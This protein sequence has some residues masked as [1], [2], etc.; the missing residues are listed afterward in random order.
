MFQHND[1]NAKVK[2]TNTEPKNFTHRRKTY[3]TRMHSDAQLKSF[4]W[5]VSDFEFVNVGEQ[6][7][8]HT[9]HL[10][11]VVIN[12]NRQTTN[13]HVCVAYRF[14][15]VHLVLVYARVKATENATH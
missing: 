7:K 3:L 2:H 6:I 12:D 15:F 10:E 1:E 14:H 9:R 5:Q 8:G 11:G 4:L 13:D